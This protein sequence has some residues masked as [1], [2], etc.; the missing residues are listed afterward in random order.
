MFLFEQLQIVLMLHRKALGR[1]RGV[2]V[3]LDHAL[4]L[5]G[6][7]ERLLCKLQLGSVFIDICVER[8][9]INGFQF[10]FDA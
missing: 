6:R 3:L 9:T 8:V 10:K 2:R 7:S 4:L 1:I 5:I